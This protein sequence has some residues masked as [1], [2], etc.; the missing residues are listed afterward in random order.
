MKSKAAAV[1]SALF[2]TLS[3]M[4][5]ANSAA[6]DHQNGQISVSW[7]TTDMILNSSS[8]IE[9]EFIPTENAGF[10]DGAQ[11]RWTNGFHLNFC[12][13]GAGSLTSSGDR[14]GSAV[15][16]LGTKNGSNYFGNFDFAIYNAVDYSILKSEQNL[17]CNKNNEAGYIGNIQTHYITCWRGIVLQIGTPYVIRVQ[18]DSS[19]SVSDN[20]WWSATLT[21]KNTNETII[22]GKIK[23]TSNSFNERLASL[24]TIVFYN[25]DPKPC[26]AVPIYDVQVTPPKSRNISSTYLN[27][28]VGTCVKAYAGESNENKGY[29]SIRLGGAEPEKREPGYV[30]PATPSASPVASATPNTNQ[31]SAKT[32]PIAPVFSGIKISGNT[33][34]ISVNLG[35]SRPDT[36]YLIAPKLSLNSQEKLPGEINGDVA[37]WVINFDPNLL[38]GNIP[39]RFVSTKDGLSSN[40][41][42]IDYLIPDLNQKSNAPAK[43]PAAPA[44]ITSRLV[45]VDLLVSA[46]IITNG[47]NAATGVSL[48]SKTL[49]I[50]RSKAIKGNLIANGVIFSVPITPNALNQ[51]ID[52]NLFSSNKIGDSQVVVSSFSI[53]VPKSP[54]YTAGNQNT[55]TVVCS[56]GQTIRTF[57]SKNCP[58]G[59]KVK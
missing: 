49:G 39:L 3:L 58:P 30:S 6:N 34:N 32:K 26:D 4:T 20:N 22:N 21:N 7:K 52:L 1:V 11:H 29:Y 40:E 14:C 2:L 31:V 23:A 10:I 35:S 51:K 57:L 27:Q 50:S 33:L 8:Y 42:K 44:K 56:K 19:N 48:Y 18:W 25:G 38:K 16:G 37:K 28:R 5:P 54:T 9:Q 24:Q 36:V 41:T 15:V 43:L 53:P 46:K 59:W 55:S 47:A 12:W 17:F 45:G 13:Q